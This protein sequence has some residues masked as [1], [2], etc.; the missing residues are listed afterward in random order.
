MSHRTRLLLVLAASIVASGLGIL[1]AVC[2][3]TAADG[4]RGG[5][6]AVM[7]S[8]ATLFA[9]HGIPAS[10]LEEKDRQG[11]FILRDGTPEAKIRVLANSFAAY[12][13]A[14]RIDRGILVLASLIGTLTWGFGDIAA[15]YLGAAGASA[16]VPAGG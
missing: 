5:A 7:I 6:I 2:W 13:D 16:P 3:G 15:A 8:F 9:E 10:A 1:Y 4:G 12:L 14:A 11:R